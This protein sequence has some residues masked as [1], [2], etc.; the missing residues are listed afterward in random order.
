MSQVVRR[1]HNSLAREDMRANPVSALVKRIWW[2]LRWQIRQ[3][4]WPLAL[5]NGLHM[6]APRSGSAALIYYLGTSEPTTTA[7]LN[8][9][10]RAGM[11]VLD[12]GAH[13]G[14]YTLR[15]S[16][17]V[18][19]SGQVHAFEPN[20]VIFRYLERN[21]AHSPLDNIIVQQA[22]VADK[23]GKM[24]FAIQSEPSIS[25]LVPGA[26]QLARAPVRTIAVPVQTLDAYCVEYGLE[27]VDFIKIDIEGAELLAFKGAESLLSQPAGVAPAIY[28]EFTERLMRPFGYRSA[29]VLEY[30]VAHG[31]TVFDCPDGETLIE[32]DCA[33]GQAPISPNLLATKR[34]TST[35]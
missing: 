26:D 21:A 20:P 30:L 34:G 22:A 6:I 31:Y 29:D 9:Y 16:Q 19:A 5:D 18:G 23:Q 25:S 10:L 33:S 1:F 14:E 12:I 3:D 2:K 11:V 13:L 27:Q 4:D 8:R 17:L 15:A 28:F 32:V 7:L 35:G 24:E